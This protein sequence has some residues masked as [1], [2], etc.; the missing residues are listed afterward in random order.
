MTSAPANTGKPAISVAKPLFAG[1]LFAFACWLSIAFTQLPGSLS[2]LWIA[3][4]ILAGILLTSPRTAWRG[5]VIAA[6][7][8]NVIVRTAHGEAWH[9]VLA[10]GFASTFDA[11][12]V[13]W[14]LTLSVADVADPA[15]VKLVAGIA[16]ISAIIAG[17]LSGLIAASVRTGFDG[18]SFGS[19]F[20]SWFA[21]HTLGIVIFATLTVLARAQGLRLL[22]QRGHRIDLLLSTLFTG[23]I[24]VGVFMATRYPLLFLVYP[25]LLVI[26]FRH[27]FS[28]VFWGVGLVTLIA[29]V[30]AL[31]GHGPFQSIPSL[32]PPER[33]LLLQLFIAS[34]CLL[35]LPIAIVMT[36]RDLLAK[37]LRESDRRYR[38]LAEYSRDLVVRIAADGTHLYVSPSA[39]AMLGWDVEELSG[40]RMD[41]VHPEDVAALTRAI[42]S[43]HANGGVST[44]TYRARHKDGHYISIEAQ[45]RLVPGSEPGGSPEIIYSGRDVTQRIEIEQALMRNQR[46]LLAITDNMP[47]FVM[48]VDTDERYTFANAPTRKIM[49]I[50]HE[51]FVGMTV[52]ELIGDEDYAGIKPRIDAAFRGETVS[53]EIERDFSG[54][55]YYYQSTY[56]PDVDPD[57]RIVGIYVMSSDISQLKRTE[58][59]LTLLA[60]YDSL[61]GLANRL[62]FNEIAETALA[63]HRR[64]SQPLALL[65]LDIDHFKQINDNHGH[66]VGDAVLHEFA[67]RL[68]GC[69]RVT[70]FVARLGGDE[71]VVLVE[72][73]DAAEVPEFIAHKML[74][75]MQEPILAG[76]HILH[77]STNIGIAF[78]RRISSSRD[79]L[80][81]IADK[82]LYAAKAAG[83]GTCRTSIIE[84]AT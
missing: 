54:L 74:A 36:E 2:M 37:T 4:G 7:V 16:T 48:H 78:C 22:G 12:L 66:A 62:H 49:G 8:G 33:S 50:D 42:E 21:A 1:T 69:V 58:R 46:R 52:R 5:Y 31:F 47:A 61:T 57:G 10:L 38:M 75:A 51:A 45:A 80:L 34:T 65:Y 35:S 68:K 24:C 67:Q 79:E 53:F 3:S 25:P 56:V 81:H 73:A 14:L 41:L 71:F 32:T 9:D 20:A 63:R 28:G 84:D 13:A 43:L 83:R 6:I 44:I 15:S 26:A 17:A 77:T 60:R 72:D 82:T 76:G 40:R 23:A 55:V 70:D 30:E 59:E 39:T 11:V 18:A 19:T 29:T 64:N 27:R